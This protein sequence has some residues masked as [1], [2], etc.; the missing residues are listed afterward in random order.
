MLTKIQWNVHSLRIARAIKLV[1]MLPTNENR[2]HLSSRPSSTSL[3]LNI[4]NLIRRNQ[5]A[6]LPLTAFQHQAMENELSV[7]SSSN[8]TT[9]NH[10]H[11]Q[12]TET[13]TV[14]LRDILSRSG[15]EGLRLEETTKPHALGTNLLEGSLAELYQL[16]DT[17][18][19]V[20]DPL[21]ANYM[22]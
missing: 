7:L 14:V 1:V 3:F 22:Q 20:L 21:R 19:E 12:L 2:R 16:L 4:P 6:V 13:P 15:D 17:Q 18:D 11:I 5:L 8:G 9:R 10:S